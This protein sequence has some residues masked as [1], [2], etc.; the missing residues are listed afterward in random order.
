MARRKKL[1]VG[2]VGYGFMDRTH[3]HAFGKVN[4]FFNL[5]YEPVLKAVCGRDKEKVGSFAEAW[6][7]E[8]Y[9]TDWR[10]LSER[11]DIHLIDIAAPNDTHAEIALAAAVAGKM[12]MCERPLGRSSG[13]SVKM[14]E[15][16][17]RA[18]VANMVWYNY[19]RVPAITLAKPLIDE[20][21][22]GRIYH[23]RAK[24]QQDWTISADLPQGGT[25][26]WRLD[27]CVA[28]SGVTGY[29]LAHCIDTAIWL[30]GGVDKVTAM[31]ET[32]V[33]E[34]MHNLTGKVEPVR[35]RRHQSLPCPLRQRFARQFRGDALRAGP[36]GALH[37]RDQWRTCVDLLGPA[38]SPPPLVF[39]SPRRENP[40]RLAVDPHYRW[41]PSLHE[42]L[43]GARPADRLRA[44]FRPPGRRLPGWTRHRQ[45]GGTDFP[46]CAC[47]RPSDGRGA[48]IGEIR[49]MGAAVRQGRGGRQRGFSATTRL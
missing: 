34:R 20:G 11:S 46:G 27:A 17:E 5:G 49:P 3:S 29:L 30:N 42:A 33:K 4:Q 45:T 43:V 8:S 44:Y 26:L 38:R 36:Q 16:V 25:G 7:Y 28:G 35:H 19:R 22:L 21:R 6:N 48:A 12:A 2:L 39:R 37:I 1:N 23:Y 32:F 9:E 10:K 24:F 18:N 47:H 15:A 40:A 14:T 31:T 41:R 13:E